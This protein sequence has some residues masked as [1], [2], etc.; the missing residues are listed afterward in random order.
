MARQGITEQQVIEAAEGLAASGQAVTVSTVREALGG[1]GSF[2]TINAHLGKWKEGGGA[3]PVSDVPDMPD[4]ISRAARAFWAVAW[5]EAQQEVKGERE[6]LDLARRDMERDRRD[7]AA[8]IARL[9]AETATQ[10]DELARLRTDLA[11][12]AAAQLRAE[13]AAQSL[14]VEN[15]RLDERAKA[16]DQRGADL[17]QELTQL[18]ARFQEVAAKVQRAAPAVPPPQ[19][20]TAQKPKPARAPA[21]Q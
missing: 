16:A 2:S 15:A 3:R 20:K 14:R 4:P 21:G 7:M 6:A 19:K 8:E 17:Q 10:A 11:E 5:K 9:E 13:E 12:Q 18:H 1:T